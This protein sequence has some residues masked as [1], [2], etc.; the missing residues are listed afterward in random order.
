MITELEEEVTELYGIWRDGERL[1]P[2]RLLHKGY[3]VCVAVAPAQ[4]I[5]LVGR[6]HVGSATPVHQ[7]AE[8]EKRSRVHRF[9]ESF[10]A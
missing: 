2:H 5:Q 8:D 6:Y 1:L 9:I 7:L 3:S 10:S 4:V